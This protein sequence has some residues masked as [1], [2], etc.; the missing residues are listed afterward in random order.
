MRVARAVL[1]P[2]EPRQG[3]FLRGGPR[4]VA[5]KSSQAFGI[6]RA[7]KLVRA[8]S[9]PKAANPLGPL[10]AR[11]TQIAQWIGFAFLKFSIARGSLEVLHRDGVMANRADLSR[12][13]ISAAF[14]GRLRHTREH[15][16][17]CNRSNNDAIQRSFPEDWLRH[18]A[19]SS[20]VLNFNWSGAE[21]AGEF[22]RFCGVCHA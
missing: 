19:S 9:V 15:K 7:R 17:Q 16:R 11:L 14:S 1:R 18:P 4:T 5:Q 21:P 10:P 2:T 3:L 22:W 12:F 8:T 20:I 6:A 13:T